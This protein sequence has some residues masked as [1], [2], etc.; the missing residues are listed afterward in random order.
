MKT[1]KN[2]GINVK[3]NSDNQDSLLHQA[4]AVVVYSEDGG[5]DI[6]VELPLPDENNFIPLEEVTDEIIIGW[7]EALENGNV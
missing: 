6:M 2:V 7:L 4:V 5:E 1:I 3:R